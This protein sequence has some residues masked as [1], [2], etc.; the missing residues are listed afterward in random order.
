MKI[1]QI[2]PGTFRLGLERCAQNLNTQKRHLKHSDEPPSDYPSWE[3]NYGYYSYNVYG[4]RYSTAQE[5]AWIDQLIRQLIQAVEHQ[6]N[7]WH[8]ISVTGTSGYQ[9]GEGWVNDGQLR[10][11][12]ATTL[13]AFCKDKGVLPEFEQ[14]E[15]G[16][17][18][19][20]FNLPEGAAHLEYD[21]SKPD[22][23]GSGDLVVPD[24]PEETPID[25]GTEIV[26]LDEWGLEVATTEVV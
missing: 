16:L 26:V 13:M 25:A 15:D 24:L 17:Y 9:T 2:R 14:D 20:P 7:R 23:D 8:R 11:Y 1:V 4:G 6:P 12:P 19:L 10:G 3:T 18:V 5:R 21:P 22:W